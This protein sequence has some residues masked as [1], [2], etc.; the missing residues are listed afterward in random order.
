MAES[1]ET[2]GKLR[3][4]LEGDVRG[5]GKAILELLELREIEVP[6]SVHAQAL[7]CTDLPTLNHWFR[8]AAKLKSATA[9]A[10]SRPDGAAHKT[11]K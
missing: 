11:A 9:V 8:R 5:R 10:R 3:G 4:K 1:R 2:T 6:E 7:A